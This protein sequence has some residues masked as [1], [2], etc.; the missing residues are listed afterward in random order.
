MDGL[1]LDAVTQD[2]AHTLGALNDADR[3]ALQHLES[4]HEA[5]L[6]RTLSWAEINTGSGNQAGLETLAPILMEAFGA[7]DADVEW[8]A[9][10]MVERVTSTGETATASTGPVIHVRS[11]Q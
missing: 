9:T 3:A 4:R 7:L 6:G 10:P 1:G 5:M 2:P 8:V 11:N